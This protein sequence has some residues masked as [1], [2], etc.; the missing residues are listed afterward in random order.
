MGWLVDL[1]SQCDLKSLPALA[2]AMQ[3]DPAWPRQDRRKRETLENNLRHLDAG[4]PHYW[5]KGAGRAWMPALASA[6][7]KEEHE[8]EELIEH[9][10]DTESAAVDTLFEFRMFPSLRRVDV[11]EEGPFPGVPSAI[12]RKGGPAT[13]R[14]WWVAPRGAGKTLVGR[15][16]EYKGWTHQ[17]S[18]TW[19]DAL[20]DLPDAG[21]VFLELE[22][23]AGANP[24]SL[25][26]REGLRICVAA[27]ALPARSAT[28]AVDAVDEEDD[29]DRFGLSFLDSPRQRSASDRVPDRMRS[30]GW[31]V[32]ETRPFEVWFPELLR[33]VTS[34]VAPGGG[35]DVLAVQQLINK[36]ERGL[37][38]TPGDVIEFLG[39][40]DQV[41]LD[42]KGPDAG[43]RWVSAWM[44][45]VVART[46]PQR[47]A[48][49]S[50]VLRNRGAQLLTD[51]VRERLVR[52]LG[53]RLS[54]DEW[55]SLVPSGDRRPSSEDFQ[56]L[57]DAN[58][59]DL[60]DR[61][62][63]LLR[64]DGRALVR[65]LQAVGAMEYVDGGYT[66]SPTWVDGLVEREAF[67]TL[68]QSGADGIG[69]LLLQDGTSDAAL[70]HLLDDATNGNWGRIRQCAAANP[71]SPSGCAAIDGAF[72]VAGMALA[73]GRKVPLAV[74][75]AVWGAQRALLVQRYRN[76]PP[77]PLLGVREAD[78]WHGPT[79]IGAWFLAAFALTRELGRD[80][81]LQVPASLNP[82]VVPDDE[83]TATAQLDALERVATS[84][85]EEGDDGDTD[86]VAA[87]FRL[88]EHLLQHRGLLQRHHRPLDLLVPAAVVGL[89][90]GEDL[91]VDDAVLREL[92]ELRCGLGPIQAAADRRGVPMDRV[93]A[94]CWERWSE[95]P[96][97][98]PPVTWSHPG[99]QPDRRDEV[100]ALWA[101]LPLASVT[102]GVLN[103]LG[104][105][106]EA[107]PAVSVE[108]WQ[109]W[110]DAW[111]P[112]KPR[113][114]RERVFTVLPEDLALAVVRSGKVDPWCHEVRR[115]L[116]GRMPERLLSLVDELIV[117]ESTPHP[118]VPGH[119]G[120]V[121]DLVASAP[122]PQQ[123][124]LVERAAAW[125]DAPTAYPGAG[126]WVVRWLVHVVTDRAGAW[127]EA[128]E[129]VLRH[130]HLVVG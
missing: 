20:V 100:A 120:V 51:M 44:K 4:K 23:A 105:V 103:A 66:L 115:V 112:R 84:F 113:H 8:I 2:K 55:A 36:L 111:E 9:P 19:T 110:L 7:G 21:R 77:V 127:R 6:L 63:E 5:L 106:R 79:S 124:A 125:L 92:L 29:D 15:W 57:A 59:P 32:E 129:L 80:S 130:R 17:V 24:D 14:T 56:A 69:A 58:P 1:A 68:Y 54:A 83:P 94:W 88:G 46:D 45:A 25:R 97:S 90:A 48:G 12:V 65:A 128:F 47:V 33:W 95:G 50:E 52:G 117:Q 30:T 119:A 73:Q 43:P 62:K 99:R 91:A 16:L 109:R 85:R 31:V 61:L 74:R 123:A 126:E 118:Q 75:R 22:S 39:V 3:E 35:F 18:R 76:W 40:I 93:L 86:L 116:W 78:H 71:G 67:G 107:W 81:E 114:D 53:E 64:P 82:W 60:A 72:R 98:R 41:G 89:A 121:G 13:D 37:F 70:E 42:A 28:D 122:E 34:R 87:A 96:N 26:D 101:A 38:R 108:V 11:A 104:E 102:E 10:P 27:P 49:C